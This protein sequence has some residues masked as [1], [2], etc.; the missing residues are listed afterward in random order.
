MAPVGSATPTSPFFTVPA[1][2]YPLCGAQ[3]WAGPDPEPRRDWRCLSNCGDVAV[4]RNWTPA[5]L[6]PRRGPF[7]SIRGSHSLVQQWDAGR[8]HLLLWL[9][10]PWRVGGSLTHVSLGSQLTDYL[11]SAEHRPSRPEPSRF[12]TGCVGGKKQVCNF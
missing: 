2:L 12:P 10:R 3:W 11:L 1:S 6:C 7:A 5:T 4:N 8:A 9:V